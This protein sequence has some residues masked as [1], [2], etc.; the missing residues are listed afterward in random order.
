MS[1]PRPSL[2]DQAA[3][4]RNRARD[5]P[6][7]ARFLVD[8]AQD[9]LQ[10]RLIDVN[11]TFTAPALVTAFP[12]LWDGFLPE[13]QRVAP[14]ERL[15]LQ[16]GNHDLVIHAMALHWAEDPVGQIIQCTRA[17]RPDGLFLAVCLGGETLHELRAS[18]GQ[19]E[20]AVTGGLSPRVA[21]M[22]EIRDLGQLLGRAGLALPVADAQRLNVSYP[23]LRALAHDLRAM[24]E[25]NALAS[26]LRRPTRPAVFAQAEKIYS[27]AFPSAPGRLAA[28]FDLMFLTG[29]KPHLSQQKPLR[30]G[31]AE[32]RLAEALNTREFDETGAPV[33]DPLLDQPAQ[34]R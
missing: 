18:L 1:K 34:K 9:E 31:S 20:T 25:G 24:G 27:D 6:E 29:W 17:L 19:A 7:A 30:P 5:V 10:E 15:D 13:A 3:L 11:R 26:R 12:A 33:L 16:G 8:A 23:N 2:V 14:S 28:T 21:P 32:A 4:A 22:A